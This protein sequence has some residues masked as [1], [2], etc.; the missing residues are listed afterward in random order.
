MKTPKMRH[1]LFKNI[2]F[3]KKKNVHKM[4]R[5]ENAINFFVAS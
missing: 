2:N 4:K 1:T 5:N 3:S